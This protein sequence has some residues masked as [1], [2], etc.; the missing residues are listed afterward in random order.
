[1]VSRTLVVVLVATCA[2][3]L[4]VSPVAA[5]DNK[6]PLTLSQRLERFRQD[7]LGEPGEAEE[8]AE[9]NRRA[10]EQRRKIIRPR[11]TEVTAQPTAPR[12]APPQRPTPSV[13]PVR[14]SPRLQVQSA[15]KAQ[16]NRGL[17]PLTTPQPRNTPRE[18]RRIPPRVDID[19]LADDTSEPEVVEPVPHKAQPAPRATPKRGVP[20]PARQVER[21]LVGRSDEDA[22]FTAGSP[23]LSVAATGPRTVRVGTPA[24]FKIKIRNSGA[25]ASNVVV[26]VDVPEHAEVASAH[27]TAGTVPG[28]GPGEAGGP[29]EWKIP[30]LAGEC[31]ETLNLSLVPRSSESMDLAVRF[32]YAPE[33]SQLVVEV[34]EPKLE[35]AI[36]GPDDVLYGET[37]IYKL[38]LSNPGNGDAENVVIGLLPVGGS[39]EGIASHNMG[40]LPAGQSRTVDVELTARQAGTITIKAQAHADGGLRSEAAEQVLVRRASLQVEVEAPRMTFA[41][42]HGA[43]RVKVVNSGDAAADDVAVA[44]MLPPDA[45]YVSSSSGGHFDPQQG[46]VTWTVGSLPPGGER[47]FDMQCALGTPGDNRM[48]FVA[49]AAGD[50]STSTTSNTQVEALADLKI[51]L[52][53]PQGPIAVGSDA[54]YEVVLRNRG[55]AAAKNVEVVVFFSEGLEADSVEGP[56]YEIATGQVLFEPIASIGAGETVS[57]KVHAKAERG[58]HHVFR[59]ELYCESLGTKL[60][61]EE[62]TYFYGEE[63]IASAKK[64]SEHREPQPTPAV[65]REPQPTPAVPIEQD[66]PST[67]REL[68]RDDAP[69]PV[70]R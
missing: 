56:K 13:A 32:T 42:T 69:P 15:R 7:L 30:R 31:I 19:E 44:A 4:V 10:L 63:A 3:V 9:A 11:P 8:R 37:K 24:E 59:A 6:A 51:E 17:I 46:K 28:A 20:T 52:R 54:E 60:A 21:N 70:P 5:Q 18:A 64:D 41:G 38:T 68:P 40:T 50:V 35:M 55:S 62:A 16:P 66:S 26:T 65:E 34:Q 53:D 67:P 61:A 23:V 43:Y 33:S 57:I 22:M 29:L 36:V 14:K 25:A 48:Q 45:K 12:Q 2:A 27:A 49:T 47:S 1:M 39:T 58:G